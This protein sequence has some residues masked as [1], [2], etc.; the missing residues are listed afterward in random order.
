[1]N[2]INL[3]FLNSTFILALLL[4]GVV[5]APSVH[6]VEYDVEVIIFEN[7]RDTAVGS[8]DTLLLPVVRDAQQIPD[9]PVPGATVQPIGELRLLNEV[10]KIKSSNNHRLLYHGG[11]RQGEIDEE[12]APYMSISLGGT[13]N[14][15]TEQ[16][17]LD[18]Q[19]LRGYLTPPV[20]TQLQLSQRRSARLQ[21]GIKVWVGRFLHFETLLAYTQPGADHSFAF[22][23][24]RRMRSRQMHYIDNSKVGI[25][26]KIFPVDNSA[27]N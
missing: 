9:A 3:K 16:G 13:F 8:S 12:N 7:V 20:D 10:D 24:D 17:D 15:L 25:I 1:M 6:A 19:F 27:P 26:T 4:A 14:L 18:S 22:V 11:W 23:S 2:K 21:G 5:V